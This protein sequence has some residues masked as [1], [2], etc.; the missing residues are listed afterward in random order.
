L[1]VAALLVQLKL[2]ATD[3]SFQAKQLGTGA[4]AKFAFGTEQV[5]ALY[6]NI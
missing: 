2:S 4:L 6:K 5:I 1:E 3:L